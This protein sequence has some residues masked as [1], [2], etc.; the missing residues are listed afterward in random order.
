MNPEN[1]KVEYRAVIK[2]L[3]LE[4]I[5]PK[6]IHERMSKVYSN[7]S[8]S[9][10]TVKRWSALFKGGRRSLD[11]D[12]RSGR[13]ST[14]VNEDS[15][16]QIERLILSDRRITI[17]ELE[18]ETRLS[19]G[20]IVNIIHD[21]LNM[22]K[23]SARW[24]PKFL[25]LDLKQKR[26]DISQENLELMRNDFDKFKN[27]IVTGDETWIYHYDPESKRQSMEWH[28]PT[29]PPPKKFKSSRSVK[30]IMAT[31]FWDAEGIIHIDY[32]ETQKTIT[33]AY[34]ADLLRQLRD[35]IKA[36]RRGKLSAGVL[37]LHDNASSHTSHLAKLPCI[38]VASKS[39]PIHHILP[40]W[41]QATF[42]CFQS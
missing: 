7:D 16:K 30:K 1:E 39:F 19:H 42:T 4:G 5:A 32:L 25:T 13:P 38:S 21:H 23:I 6:E 9:Y 31:V 8:P 29:S 28:H 2:F 33:G 34:Y 20:S 40:T 36:K 24:V 10:S 15:I 41:H 17:A 35:S 37:L 11:D 26:V 3:T 18:E 22:N 27:R 12:D 14:S